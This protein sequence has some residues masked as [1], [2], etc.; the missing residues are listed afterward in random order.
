[1]LG[2]L[3]LLAAL[4]S[5]APNHREAFIQGHG[6]HLLSLALEERV[7]RLVFKA[8]SSRARSSSS[9]SMSMHPPEDKSSSIVVVD[10]FLDQA[11][12]DA[13][14]EV[15]RGLGL[16]GQKGDG[17]TASLQGLFLHLKLWS[18]ASVDTLEYLLTRVAALAILDDGGELNRNIGIQRL[19][20]LLR[21]YIAPDIVELSLPMEY[22]ES[23]RRVVNT[24]FRL[25]HIAFEASMAEDSARSSS[26]DPE[27]RVTG[28]DLLTA[29]LDDSLH[30]LLVEGILATLH[31]M[32]TTCPL[33]LMQCFKANS[34]VETSCVLLLCR[35]DISLSVRILIVNLILWCADFFFLRIFSPFG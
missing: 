30:I 3:S 10:S 35:S 2:L 7:E 6:F 27:I 32:C 8:A 9:S 16:D 17:L 34:F 4:L 11:M 5:S 20:D 26:D 24:G 22:P 19:L 21:V 33:Q 18:H 28:I 13:C 31:S 1:M 29:M 25:I 15:L 14:F 12:V 23:F